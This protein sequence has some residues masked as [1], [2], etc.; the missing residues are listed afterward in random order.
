MSDANYADKLAKSD[1]MLRWEASADELHRRVRAFHPW[2][3]TSTTWEGRGL[4]VHPAVAVSE[5]AG[6]P[7]T[8]IAADS[9]GIVVGCGE[10]SLVLRRVQ[11]QGNQ[12]TRTQLADEAK[13]H[14]AE[15]ILHMTG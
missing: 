15:A 4:K 12:L 10:G 6:A 14:I 8:V 11:L 5:A 2:P 3:G 7:G 13:R 9:D 1:G